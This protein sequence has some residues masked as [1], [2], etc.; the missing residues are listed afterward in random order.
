MIIKIFLPL[1]LTLHSF[2]VEPPNAGS[3][4][5]YQNPTF[6]K[7]YANQRIFI[8]GLDQ[9]H[10]YF[11]LFTEIT[12][13]SL[14]TNKTI[15][16]WECNN[17]RLLIFNLIT[18]EQ[19]EKKYKQVQ[20]VGIIYPSKDNPLFNINDSLLTNYWGMEWYTDILTN[21]SKITIFNKKKDVYV[22]LE[23]IVLVPQGS[24]KN[25]INGTGYVPTDNKS[26]AFS[27]N[28]LNGYA[29]GNIGD[30]M[31]NNTNIYLESVATTENSKAFSF[32]CLYLINSNNS[33][34]TMF[35][36]DSYNGEKSK[37]ARGM[38]IYENETRKWLN[39]NDFSITP[40]GKEQLSINANT[41]FYR[42]YMIKINDIIEFNITSLDNQ[43]SIDFGLRSSSLLCWNQEV[44]LQWK[45]RNNEFNNSRG[46]L[47][48][49][50]L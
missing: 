6:I 16:E 19:S 5:N 49:I 7:D 39:Y 22:Y 14:L 15:N 41:S 18:Y 46:I 48:T 25:Q 37:S 31:L 2:C 47:E 27:F 4:P 13:T 1:V 9:D 26:A 12:S 3:L 35:I 10:Y 24:Y 33:S 32:A 30:K 34:S 11:S 8:Q 44:K 36:C 17:N 40:I 50:K 38:I 45:D 21:I 42:E 28:S 29:N 20:D 23:N 43:K